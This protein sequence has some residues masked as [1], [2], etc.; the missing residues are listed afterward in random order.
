MNE[1]MRNSDSMNDDTPEQSN[2]VNNVDGNS[3][4]DDVNGSET[5]YRTLVEN[6]PVPRIL[7][8]QK[9]NRWS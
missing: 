9:F 5:R 1:K 2:A 3:I 8:G 7:N 6:V 4:L